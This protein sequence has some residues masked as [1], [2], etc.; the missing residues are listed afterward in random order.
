LK[1]SK[2]V[3]RRKKNWALVGKVEMAHAATIIFHTRKVIL[4]SSDS[5]TGTNVMK[6][7]KIGEQK[8]PFQFVRGKVVK[9]QHVEMFSNVS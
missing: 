6:L 3:K 9:F 2:T 4:T 7:G 5:K 1:H 8:T